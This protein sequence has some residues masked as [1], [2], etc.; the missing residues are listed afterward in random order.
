MKTCKRC[1]ITDS[2]PNVEFNEDG[3]CSFCQNLSVSSAQAELKKAL[4]IDKLI[5]LKEIAAQIKQEAKEKKSQYDCIIGAS[6][7]F[8]STYVIYIAKKILGLNPLVVKYDNGVCHDLANENLKKACQALGVELRIFNVIDDERKYFLNATK[9]L[10]NLGVFFSAC[11]S[12]HY[13]IA[14]VVYREAKKE[15]IRYMLTST[16]RVERNLADAS[17]GFMLKSLIKG[18]FRCNPLKMLNF[19]YYELVAQYYFVK[20]KFKFDKL[21]LRF[22]RN[23]FSL[24]PITPS[25]IKKIDI[26]QYIAWNWLKI[27]KIL[28][29]ELG[30]ETPRKTKVPYFRFDCHYSAMIDKSFKKV[31]G[32]SEHGLLF[33]WFI[34][35]GFATRQELEDDFKYMNDDNRINKEIDVIRERFNLPK[36]KIEKIL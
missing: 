13:I 6:G 28:R 22:V 2:F 34:Q 18:F 3:I 30:W 14:S 17:H 8:D 10:I 16:N 1:F 31:T 23:L 15:K 21:S 26:G 9:G 27:E 12:C 25:F 11:F 19:I 20:L 32:I 7:G 5:E 35:A 29:E 4:E 33:N 24:H 36:D